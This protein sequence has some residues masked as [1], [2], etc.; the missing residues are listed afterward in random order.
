MRPI[1]YLI[2]AGAAVFLG[3]AASGAQPL[4]PPQ[5]EDVFQRSLFYEKDIR[6]RLEAAVPT[7]QKLLIEWGG[8]YI[9]SYTYFTDLGGNNGNVTLQDLRLW[10]QIRAA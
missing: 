9:P 7:E 3:G 5:P 8:F 4:R 2:L 6:E 1:A 10:T